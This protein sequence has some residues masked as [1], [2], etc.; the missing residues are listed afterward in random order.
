MK[1]KLLLILFA[2]FST[3]CF[4][5]FGDFGVKSKCS[6]PFQNYEE[7]IK[8]HLHSKTP[9]GKADKDGEY[10]V[11]KYLIVQIKKHM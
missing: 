8:W 4:A 3:P 11:Y 7:F 1:I 6:Q 5:G 10:T 9:D 2:F